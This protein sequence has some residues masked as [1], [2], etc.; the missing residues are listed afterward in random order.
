[1]NSFNSSKQQQKYNNNKVIKRIKRE[2]F[3]FHRNPYF[4]SELH[5]QAK[6]IL[7]SKQ[8]FILQLFNKKIQEILSNEQ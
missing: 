5:C 4:I 8:K 3:I 1:M 2:S 7:K 6:Y